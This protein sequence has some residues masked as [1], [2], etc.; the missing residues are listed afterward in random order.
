V[1]LASLWRPFCFLMVALCSAQATP[2]ALERIETGLSDQPGYETQLVLFG[3]DGTVLRRLDLLPGEQFVGHD[4]EQV[5][6]ARPDGTYFRLTK[7]FQGRPQPFDYQRGSSEGSNSG[8]NDAAS[9]AAVLVAAGQ[10]LSW[11]SDSGPSA[12]SESL[13]TPAPTPATV[14][15]ATPTPEERPV[16][17]VVVRG[18]RLQCID[19]RTGSTRS[20]INLNGRVV[21]GPV[22]SGDYCTLTIESGTGRRS[23]TYK[24]PSLSLQNSITY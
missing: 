24:L 17:T 23:N 2:P 1:A 13:S 8:L 11:F 19:A 5:V 12:A 3:S 18:D 20:T 22:V 14:P 4:S 6:F 16:W 9:M 21:S 7:P 10:V 15:Q